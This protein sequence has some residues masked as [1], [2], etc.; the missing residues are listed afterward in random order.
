MQ[1]ELKF[2]IYAMK[3]RQSKAKTKEQINK[4]NP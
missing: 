1:E 2:K 4:T 3:S